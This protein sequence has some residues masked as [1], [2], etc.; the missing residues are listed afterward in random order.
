MCPVGYFQRVHPLQLQPLDQSGRTGCRESSEKPIASILGQSLTI[1]KNPHK[2][3]DHSTTGR[4]FKCS[5]ITRFV[6]LIIKRSHVT[7]LC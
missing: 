4:R 6:L 1:Q 2:N 7:P 3:N 5:G